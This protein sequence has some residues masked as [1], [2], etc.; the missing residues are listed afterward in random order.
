MSVK[1]EL[2]TLKEVVSKGYFFNIPIYQ[3]LYVWGKEQIETLLNDLWE[4]C[5]EEKPEFYLGSTLVMER[6]GYFELIDGQQRFTT[7]WLISLAWQGELQSYRFAEVD[8]RKKHRIGFAIRQNVTAYFDALIHGE[9]AVLAEAKQ[10]EDAMAFI[11]SFPTSFQSGN[12]GADK[13]DVMALTKYI[14]E[15]V[16]MLVTCVPDKTDLNKLF[17]VINNRGVQLQHHEI[18]KARL[19]GSIKDVFDRERYSVL[20]DACAGMGNYVEKN[21]QQIAGVKLYKL[22][23]EK[24]SM[25]DT[26]KLAVVSDVLDAIGDKMNSAIDSESLLKLDNILTMQFVENTA[27]DKKDS[28]EEYE[29]DTV[30]SIISFPMLLQHV[31]RIWLLNSDTPRDIEKILDKD[32]L[33]IFEKAGFD[34]KPSEE[35]VKSFIGLLWEIRY[36]FDKYII[37]WVADENEEIHAIRRLSIK[38][39]QGKLY[40]V[41]E[42]AEDENGFS[43]LQSM[44]YHSQQIT[45]HYWLTPLLNYIHKYKKDKTGYFSYLRYLDNHLLCSDDVRPLI[46]RTR[47]FVMESYVKSNLSTRVLEDKLGTGFP[48]YWFYKLEFVLWYKRED[49]GKKKRW[50]SFHMTAKNS[51]EHIA[52]Q[53]PQK[54]EKDRLEEELDGF[55]NLALVSRSINSEYSNKFFA[56]KR[57]RFLKKNL[58]NV[59]SLKMDLIYQNTHWNDSLAKKH[60]NEMIKLLNNYLNE[61]G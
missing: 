13:F 23:N 21:L 56:E 49:F 50:G 1:S 51:V 40:L 47:E 58:K 33:H 20:W 38:T 55:G 8:G 14:F 35:D 30:R 46:E 61:N 48:H 10:L 6:D 42:K 60:Q 2:I 5:Q 34:N 31:L 27:E 15:N 29:A 7:L 18:L 52:P 45:T 57:E 4:A 11:K 36:W 39:S 28:F 12:A 17:E 19:L 54:E 24:S 37:K 16:Q 59:D 26:E 43:L 3:R 32:L 9:N 44:L 22:Y 53:T 41:R 25:R